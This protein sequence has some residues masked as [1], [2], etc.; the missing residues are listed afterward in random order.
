MFCAP[1]RT[2]FSTTNLSSLMNWNK[3]RSVICA[4]CWK[5]TS[6]SRVALARSGCWR[7]PHFR[8]SASSPF[9]SR[10]LWMPPGKRLR[11]ASAIGCPPSPQTIS[12]RN[13]APRRSMFESRGI[14]TLNLQIIRYTPTRDSDYGLRSTYY[15]RSG[16]QAQELFQGG[17]KGISL[18]V[19][20]ERADSPIGAGL[21]RQAAGPL[22]EVGG[23]DAGGR[24]VV[25]ICRAA[26][27]P[28]RRIHAGGGGPRQCRAR[29]GRF[30]RQRSY[31]L[32]PA[33]GYPGGISA[34][35]PAGANQHLPQFQPQDPAAAGGRVAGP[36]DSYAAGEIAQSEDSYDQSRP[37]ALYG[38]REE[39]DGATQPRDPGG[40]R[41][42]A[43]DFPQNGVYPAGA[44]QA[45]PAVPLAAA[46]RHGIA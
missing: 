40:D 33:A 42:L 19:R 32:V 26:L 14:F 2:T 45:V 27:A 8:S 18:A 11:Y 1:K 17:T 46:H 22:R 7:S 31:V 3:R 36:G 23:A 9:T 10:E 24:G 28:A 15:V 21:S 13:P 38:E 39:S 30:W 4:D 25:R 12:G 43:A 29:P 41:L 37:A 35:L 5:P 6:H 44:G 16:I 20:G 34:A